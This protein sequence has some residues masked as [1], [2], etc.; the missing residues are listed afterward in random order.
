M[1]SSGI[2]LGT[3]DFLQWKHVIPVT[4]ENGE[5]NC[6]CQAPCLCQDIENYYTFITF[7]AYNVLKEWDGFSCSYGE[8]ITGE[9]EYA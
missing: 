4:E 2:Q 7:E 8:K 9:S 6:F 1:F 5:K 3:W